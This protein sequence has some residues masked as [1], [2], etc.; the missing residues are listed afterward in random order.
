MELRSQSIALA[1]TAHM[2]L[3]A[4]QQFILIVFFTMLSG[5][6]D[7]VAEIKSSPRYLIPKCG[8]RCTTVNSEQVD[9]LIWGQNEEGEQICHRSPDSFIEKS[10]FEF[11]R[12]NLRSNC[13]FALLRFSEKNPEFTCTLKDPYVSTQCIM[14]YDHHLDSWPPLLTRL[15][16][17]PPQCDQIIM[18]E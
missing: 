1:Y 3:N 4:P 5:C 6:A 15:P 2:F 16:E 8:L 13:E 18:H 17:K 11:C 14:L 12:V 10:M 7:M 9:L